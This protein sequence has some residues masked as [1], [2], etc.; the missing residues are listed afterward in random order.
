MKNTKKV[1]VPLMLLATSVMVAG[2]AVKDTTPETSAPVTS[3]EVHVKSLA[4]VVGEKSQIEVDS[5]PRVAEKAKFK[6]V[7][8]NVKVATVDKNGL[9]TS[10]GP[11]LATITVSNLD[12]TVSEDIRV[13]V[14]DG[15]LTVS[16]CKRAAATIQEKQAEIRAAKA[17]EGKVD[18]SK[19]MVIKNYIKNYNYING[20]ISTGYQGYENMILSV[21]DAYFEINGA[22][23]EQKV[24]GGNVTLNE[25]AWIFYTNSSWQTY[26]FHQSG[27]TKTYFSVDTSA[28][29]S[30][31][32]AT[33][34][35]C[36]MAILD[37]I[38]RS[39]SGIATDRIG[40]GDMSGSFKGSGL[41]KALI[42]Q[43]QYGGSY[44]D[45]SL[46]FDY[47]DDGDTTADYDDE[48][49]SDIPYGTRYHIDIHVRGNVV[50]YWGADRIVEQ[51]VTYELDGVKYEQLYAGTNSIYLWDEDADMPYPDK[52]EYSV[53]DSLFDL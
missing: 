30:K 47:T 1:L 45:G 20:A 19:R 13:S 21:P 35:D 4:L 38:F 37:N 46:M 31:E 5:L 39:G 10:V 43:V 2:C 26:L 9:V 17:A 12:G 7:S 27:T 49:D 24:V 22:E 41:S 29:A 48:H 28:I 25:Y 8:S 53:V 3:L 36:V 32:G 16:D 11:G 51:K 50:D 14:T 40:Y 6:Y 18:P 52:N 42:E 44:G 33:R 23:W 15:Q 34:W